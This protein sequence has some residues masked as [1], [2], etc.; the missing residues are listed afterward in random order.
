M[1]STRRALLCGAAAAGAAAMLPS[2]SE[3]AYVRPYG[4]GALWNRPASQFSLHSDSARLVGKLWDSDR[5]TERVGANNFNVST[6]EWSFPVYSAATATVQAKVVSRDMGGGDRWSP[7]HGKLV[8]W[9]PAWKPSH[10][11]NWPVGSDYDSQVIVLDPATGREWNYWQVSYNAT[12]NRLTISNGNL[13][14]GSYLTNEAGFRGSRGAGIPYYA[15][16]VM[17]EEVQQGSIEHCMTLATPAVDKVG[18]FVAPATKS[19]G[20]LYGIVGGVP[21]GQRFALRATDSEIASWL[22]TLPSNVR[23]AARVLAVCARDYGWIVTD[24]AGSTHTQLADIANP[25]TKTAWGTLGMGK[26]A[27]NGKEYPRDLYDGLVTKDRL[28]ALT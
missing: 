19:D 25:A 24:Y 8:P 17:P 11:T 21:E 13:A 3:A 15:M 20:D 14:P 23:T 27:V 28:V 22:L 5:P 2:R 12:Y 1:S 26:Q 18:T 9:N 6:S 4:P 10:G 7:L 16:L